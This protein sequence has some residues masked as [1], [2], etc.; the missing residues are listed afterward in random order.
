[1]D[2]L[3]A[4]GNAVDAAV[5]AALVGCVVNVTKCGIGGYGGHMVIASPKGLW[6]GGRQ[7]SITAIDFN[8]TAPAAARPDM[9]PLDKNG[10]VK[11]NVN[12]RGWLAVSVPGT[13]AGLQLALDRY[14]TLPFSRAVQPAIA[15]ARNGFPFLY[16]E[17]FE[18]EEAS[19]RNR[20]GNAA[21]VRLFSRNGKP[22]KKGDIHR[23]PDLADMLEQL[24]DNDSADA[25]YRGEIGQR[26]AQAFQ[27]NGGLVTAEDMASYQAREVTPLVL[28]W[29]GYQIATA[30]LTSGGLTILQTIAALKAMGWPDH[31]FNSKGSPDD[32][33]VPPSASRSIVTQAW[34][35]ALRIAWG[36]RLELFGDPAYVEVPVER[37]L[38]ERYAKRSAD[39][40]KVA[41]EQGR[42]VS[43]AGDGQSADGTLHVSAV[44]ATGMMVALTLTLGEKFGAQVAVDGVGLVLGHGMSRFDPVPGRPNSIAPGKRPLHNMCPTIVVRDGHPVLAIGAIGSRRIPNAILQVLLG[45]IAEGHNLEESVTRPRL[46]TEGGMKLYAEPG[47][48]EADLNHLKQVGYEIESMPPSFVYTVERPASN[49]LTSAPAVGVADHLADNEAQ[50]TGRDPKPIVTCA[51]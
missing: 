44:D 23:N 10:N 8:T 40:V 29:R 32:K 6:E 21:F 22:L 47:A 18:E 48:P 9:F 43:V 12:A 39:R 37:L 20:P 45:F 34:I 42:P 35:E 28:D 27:K 30:P 7:D 1:M 46:H 17:P 50:I 2:I 26:I 4:G 11:G 25:F 13:L 33:E 24:A 38:S 31:L 16:S 15:Y 41:L 51:P 19:D 36:D 14:G 49:S 5:A 3:A